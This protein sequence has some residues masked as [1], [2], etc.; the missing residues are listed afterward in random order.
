MAFMKHQGEKLQNRQFGLIA[1]VEVWERFAFYAFNILFVLYATTT[2]LLTE[3]QA[4]M[5]FGI[6]SA[7]AFGTPLIGG[8]VA[9]RILGAKTTLIFGGIL[10]A[11]GY[12]LL[13]LS[14][15]YSSIMLAL[16][17][18]ATGNGF[19]KPNPSALIG[20]IFQDNPAKAQSS[21]TIYYMAINIGSLL[22]KLI[23]PALAQYGGFTMSFWFAT[24]GMIFALGNF[25][26]RYKL[27]K[28]IDHERSYLTN[29]ASKIFGVSI[30]A[31]AIIAFSYYM[32]QFTNIAFYLI[33][34]VTILT[35]MSMISSAA[36]YERASFIKQII[37]T[38]LFIEAIIF[39]IV[40]TQMFTTIV[41]F[42]QH[43][44]D[45]NI[46]GYTISPAALSMFNPMWILLLSPILAKVYMS[47]FVSKNIFIFDKFYIA[48]GLC[49]IA[50]IIL[51]FAC[52]FASNS[53]I[54]GLWMLIYYFFAALAELLVSALGLAV[55]AQYF[56]REKI[57]FCMGAWLLSTAC[58]SA[59]AGK[60]AGGVA[61]NEGTST[62][63]SLLMFQD[64]F[65]FL[66][67]ICFIAFI[68]YLLFSI[69]IRR[70]GKKYQIK[71]V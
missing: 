2:G 63:Q 1:L 50:F 32:L 30:L 66:A 70:I 69:V 55:A 44:V 27:L 13:A 10:L 36:N 24:G 37:G 19:F 6:F 67:L 38:V 31:L 56:P 26:I 23:S 12:A 25:S 29:Q 15:G 45:L 71:L 51:Y 68:C 54:S 9:D 47:K 46:M 7:L 61:I 3:S 35:Y 14:S 42:A 20:K 40:Y 8:F 22:A 33:I 28:N 17:V 59:L 5:V 48:L 53:K 62:A 60:I 41:L 65:L 16:S 21:F 49:A 39:F 57:S 52:G 11:I 58:G 18:I 43:N 34:M 64:Y 4:Y